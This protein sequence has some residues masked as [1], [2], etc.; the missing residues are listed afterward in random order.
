MY[1]TKIVLWAQ[2]AWA[3]MGRGKVL[4]VDS[5]PAVDVVLQGMREGIEA[6]GEDISA[7]VGE[8]A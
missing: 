1:G 5:C 6:N 3:A 2:S 8:V 4:L 7:V